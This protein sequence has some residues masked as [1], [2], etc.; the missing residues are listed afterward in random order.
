MII[1]TDLSALTAS[2]LPVRESCN[3]SKDSRLSEIRL[4][5]RPGFYLN[6]SKRHLVQTTQLWAPSYEQ[7]NSVI[8]KKNA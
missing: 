1:Y 4:S 7:G 3:D 6:L 8:W 5:Q 2:F